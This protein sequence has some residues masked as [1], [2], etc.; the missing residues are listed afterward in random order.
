MVNR[1]KANQKRFWDLWE[2][3]GA[4]TINTQPCNPKIFT[5]G[6]SILAIDGKSRNVETWVRKIAQQAKVLIDWHYSGGIAHVLLLG[7]IGDWERAQEHIE[8]LSPKLIGRI[9]RK[10]DFEDKGLYRQGVTPLPEGAQMVFS[11]NGDTVF[12]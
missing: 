12:A 9:I 11:S 4:V 7:D 10:Y 2:K 3:A 6:K 5:E 8:M 1:S